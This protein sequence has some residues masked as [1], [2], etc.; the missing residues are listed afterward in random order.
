[1]GALF[2]TEGDV[3]QLIDMRE[4]MDAVEAAF[5]HLAAGQAENEPRRRV[6]SPG[7]VFHS[8]CAS[9]EYL[10]T[11]GWKGYTTTRDG[12]RFH[13]NLYD[14][15]TGELVA[16]IEANKLGQ[17]R[18]GA[19]T[20][21]AL[22]TM[23]R[24]D[25][26]ELG[27]FG[28]GWQAESQL[29]AVLVAR[30]VSRVFVYSRSAERR[31]SFAEEMSQRFN[32]E[33]V[34]VDRPQEAAAEL[35][36]VVT[37]TSSREPV[38]DGDWLAEGCTVCAVGSNWLGKAEID[39]DVV[40]RAD[41]I[42]C[43]DVECCR[44]EAGDFVDALEKGI[45]DWSRA[46]SLGQVVAGEAVGRGKADDVCLFK[47]VGMAIEDVAVAT[48]LWKKAQAANVGMDLPLR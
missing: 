28:T 14:Q 7:I 9:A 31:E 2:L 29:E 4:V 36:L 34:P 45:F 24:T 10:G 8:M 44:L 41:H 5:R 15:Q 26:H 37:A 20:G 35:P 27:L 13:V 12:A 21:V 40:R 30:K 25:A 6:K 43:D 33:V 32:I 1:M 11:L 17:M 16:L 18:T 19:T 38:F 42:V 46:V 39:S 3:E 23:A 48:M 22:E 47:S